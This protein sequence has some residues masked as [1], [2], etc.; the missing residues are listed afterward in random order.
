MITGVRRERDVERVTAGHRTRSSGNVGVGVQRTNELS[1][2]HGVGDI[3]AGFTIV[4]E[5]PRTRS[6]VT[7]RRFYTGK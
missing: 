7:G 3:V 6:C 2:V 5:G 4:G 1:G